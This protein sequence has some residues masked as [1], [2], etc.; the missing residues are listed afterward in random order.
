[1]MGET[2]NTEV[3]HENQEREDYK[4]FPRNE[5]ILLQLLLGRK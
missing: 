4:M 3:K 5:S 1:M 2:E